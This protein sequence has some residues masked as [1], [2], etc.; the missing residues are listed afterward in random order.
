TDRLHRAC[1]TLHG[2]AN[3]AN[4]ERGIAVAG[5]LNRY[6]RRA[7]DYNLGL[8]KVGIEA[9]KAAAE[10][11]RTIVGDI[12]QP[13]RQRADFSDLISH[14]SALTDAIEAPVSEEKAPEPEAFEAEVPRQPAESEQEEE[15]EY[16][17]EIAAIFSEEAAELLEEADRV[18]AAWSKDK[19]S[20]EHGEELNRHLHT[21]K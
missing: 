12:N 10:A 18:L 19:A 8:E 3:M 13:D 2:S 16:D 14:L 17:A 15:G 5:A 21:L 1:H 9:L 6:V 20:R 7:Y 4:V 11:I